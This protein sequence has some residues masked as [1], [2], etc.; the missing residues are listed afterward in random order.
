MDKLYGGRTGALFGYTA[1]L[2]AWDG[3]QAEWARVPWADFNCIK[4]PSEAV[5]PDALAI[6]LSDILCTS[7]HANELGAV[8]EGE[9]RTPPRCGPADLRAAAGAGRQVGGG[10]AG[11][12]ASAL[13]RRTPDRRRSS[14]RRTLASPPSPP[15]DTVAI[16]GAGPVGQLCAMWARYRGARKVVVVDI[17]EDRLAVARHKAGADAVV[18]ASKHDVIHSIQLLFPNGP[19]VCIDAAGFRFPKELGQKLQHALRLST[20]SSSILNEIIT[21]CQKGGRL[22]LIG[23]YVSPRP[24]LAAVA[25]AG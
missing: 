23:D 9:S 14:P 13:S 10:G 4:L 18:D 1:L 16:W 15:G 8:S 19:T 22:V 20:D 12:A 25:A 6:Q 11:L 3:L 7:W 24:P 17:D 21:C 5:V 2:G